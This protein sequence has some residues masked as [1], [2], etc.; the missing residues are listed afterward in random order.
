MPG[1]LMSNVYFARP[2]TLSG[3]SSRLT[4]VPITAGFAGQRY[5]SGAFGGGGCCSPRPWKLSG[6]GHPLHLHVRLEDAREGAAAADVAVETFLDLIDRRVRVFLVQRDR[7]HDEARRAEA[8]HERI[9]VAER[10]LDRMQ[11]GAAGEAVYRADLLAL[12][13]D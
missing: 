3:P 5:F 1:R 8:A 13:V 2:V 9:D 4:G 6:T 11:R 7:R 12:H 10:L